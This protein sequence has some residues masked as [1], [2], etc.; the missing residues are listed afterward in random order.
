MCLLTAI[1][2]RLRSATRFATLA[3]GSTT[4]R[5]PATQR[6]RSQIIIERLRAGSLDELC[7]QSREQ[8]RSSVDP[9]EGVRDDVA[10]ETLAAA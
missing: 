8:V 7:D 4:P 9:G 10:R 2:S 3:F 6:D 5:S 1:P